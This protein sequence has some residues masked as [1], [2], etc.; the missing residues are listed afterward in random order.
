MAAAGCL[1]SAGAG[2]QCQMMAGAVSP[3]A[4]GKGAIDAG[5]AWAR[6]LVPLARVGWVGEVRGLGG[7]GWLGRTLVPFPLAWAGWWGR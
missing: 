4:A 5:A 1:V 3:S 7:A 6:P 2:C